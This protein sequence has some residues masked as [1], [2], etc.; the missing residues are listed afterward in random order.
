MTLLGT[1]TSFAFSFLLNYLLLFS[2]SLTPFARSVIT[3]IALPIVIGAPLSFLLA[4]SLRAV[5]RYRRELTRSASYD[6]V[7]DFFNGAAFTS[8]VDRRASSRQEEGARRGAFLLINAQGLRSINM[9]YGHEWGEEALRLVASTIRSSVRSDDI[10]GRLGLG[11][12]GIFLPGATEE[13][14]RAVGE[15]IRAGVARVYLQP[16]RFGSAGETGLLN[17]SVG[18]VIFEHELEFDGLYR[19]AGQQLSYAEA[20]GGIEIL[21][22]AS[23]PPPTPDAPAAH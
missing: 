23:N 5:R 12:F 15:R 3:A 17:V 11:E 4:Y 16:T 2:D 7:T 6:Q 21:P 9:R 1:C 22:V 19:V 14:A 10:V 8:V 13:N 18:G 20:S